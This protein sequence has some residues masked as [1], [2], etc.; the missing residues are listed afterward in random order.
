VTVTIT[1][2]YF[3]DFG[4]NRL[5]FPRNMLAFTPFITITVAASVAF[6]FFLVEF[7]V[8]GSNSVRNQL[9]TWSFIAI[10]V[11]FTIFYVFPML[12]PVFFIGIN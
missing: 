12:F 2:A 4:M 11:A 10:A 7:V 1:A 5:Y 6:P 3:L 9:A 8:N